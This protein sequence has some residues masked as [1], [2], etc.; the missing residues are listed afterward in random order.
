MA[1]WIHSYFDNVI[2]KFVIDNR[3]DAFDIHVL[4]NWTIDFVTFR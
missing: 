3:T 4:V 2:T 1:S